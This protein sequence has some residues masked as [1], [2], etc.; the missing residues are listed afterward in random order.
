MKK[1]N[2]KERKREVWAGLK[3]KEERTSSNA[4]MAS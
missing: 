2:G 3:K 1:K 4:D